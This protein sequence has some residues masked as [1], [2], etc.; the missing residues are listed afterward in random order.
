LVL[1]EATGHA[2]AF[3][4]ELAKEAAASKGMHVGQLLASWRRKLCL[5]SH[6]AHADNVMRGL[7]AAPD[8]AEVASSS[9]GMPSPATSFFTRAI[10][11]KRLRNSSNG[12]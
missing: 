7:S 9:A 10:G 2:T 12:V 1:S 8:D 6:V 3:L 5:A 11:R 4:T